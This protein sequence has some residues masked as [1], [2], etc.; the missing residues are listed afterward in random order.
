[1]LLID[2][3]GGGSGLP[4]TELSVASRSEHVM[5]LRSGENM[6][7]EL[8]GTVGGQ[9][10]PHQV[11]F[12]TGGQERRVNL[13]QVGRIYLGNY[14]YTSTAQNEGSSGGTV[15]TG[16]V[17]VP[18][19]ATWV[20][21]NMM[22]RRGD[23]VVFA[24]RGQVQ[25]GEATDIA[26]PAGA[27]SGRRTAGAPLPSELAG[28]LIGKVGNSAPF[29]IGDQTGAVLMPAAGQLFL[30]INDDHVNDN[31]GEFVVQ[32]QHLGLTRRQ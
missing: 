1:V 28:A 4:D 12:R 9:N 10:E 16:S 17:R 7:G 31:Q 14:P 23:R 11:V 19:N 30:G 32:I 5:F 24:A 2:L 18:G 3:V 13:D 27:R 22:V 15:P 21:A 8:V 6:T 25:L 29:A 20:P 26:T